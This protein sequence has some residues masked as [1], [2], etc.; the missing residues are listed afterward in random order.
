MQFEA[1]WITVMVCTGLWFAL[2]VYNWRTRNAR[3]V[4]EQHLSTELG[5]FNFEALFE[6]LLI[7]MNTWN[8]VM[9][10]FSI[11]ICW[12]F[13]A[14]YKIV[15][16]PVLLV[17]PDIKV[18]NESSPYYM[19]VANIHVMAFFQLFYVLVMVYR[20]AR[21]DV[22][23]IDWE[24]GRS[25][26]AAANLKKGDGHQVSVWRTILV[27]NEW[28]ELQ[29]IRKTDIRFTLIFLAFILIG[30]REQNNATQQP[31]LSD[32]SD[33]DHNTAFRFGNTGFYW[34]LLSFGQYAWKFFIAE[35]YL[36]EPPER[37]FIDF[38][39]LAKVSVIVLDEKFHGYYLHCRSPHQYADGT[40]TELVQMLHKEE[41]GLTTDRSLEGAPQG[42]QSFQIFVSG[43]WRTAFDK[44][45]IN[46]TGAE[47][48]TDILQLG[49]NRGMLS[50]AA[51]TAGRNRGGTASAAAAVEAGRRG[52][53][54]NVPPE[55]VLRA[56]K[57]MLVFL[58]EFID[59]NFGKAGLKRTVREPQYW[60]KMCNMG[61]PIVTS[62][63]PSI[64]LTDR[65]FQYTKTMF[66]G[67]ETELLLLN[68]L[69]FSVV[70]I[71]FND[72]STSILFTYLLE[73]AIVQ[74]RH[75]LGQV[76]WCW[77]SS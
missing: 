28:A 38:C 1:I 45:K 5:S 59:N 61:P 10:W 32:K 64:F 44:I 51:A 12:Y 60:E 14:Y 3:V 19:L 23:F 17:P 6:V 27:A 62:D 54:N 31:E 50:Q 33:G 22:F 35:R 70:D 34:L 66:L 69:T 73:L 75:S 56:W 65:E 52:F 40:M 39:T 43:E 2:R 47:A 4:S 26:G 63:T 13:F 49:R 29:T 72:T 68:I 67:R 30:M 9:F 46:I 42:V 7:M 24:P 41:A 77:Y 11:M 15:R 16:I 20:Q 71:W 53:V 58:Q 57:E 48:M 36:G 25:H 8:M 74:L 21:A 37:L 76:R 55:R 18:F